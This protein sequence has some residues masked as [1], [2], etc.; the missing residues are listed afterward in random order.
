MEIL[1]SKTTWVLTDLR[2]RM[3]PVLFEALLFPKVKREFWN[4]PIVA[5]AIKIPLLMVMGMIR[6]LHTQ[7]LNPRTVF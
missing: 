6:A 4:I 3:L 1:F 5:I 7:L 2:E